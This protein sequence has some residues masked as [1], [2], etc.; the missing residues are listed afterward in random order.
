MPSRTDRP[1]VTTPLAS[2]AVDGVSLGHACSCRDD[3]DE[4]ELDARAIP[5][6]IRHA[7]IFGAL[8]AVAPEASLV[9][10]APHDPLPL[11]D[12]IGQRWPGAF[13]VDYLRRGPDA[14]RLRF[15]RT[16]APSVAG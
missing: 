11:L 13:G 4:P 15:T 5:H 2:S 7:T 12:H 14:W 9:L 3:D 1:V 16:P 6:T 8:D 10:V